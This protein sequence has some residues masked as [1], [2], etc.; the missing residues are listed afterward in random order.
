MNALFAFL[1]ILIVWPGLLL[2]WRRWVA[3]Q[4]AKTLPAG[5]HLLVHS[6]PEKIAAWIFLS[7]VV[8]LGPW[9]TYVA[10]KASGTIG[11]LYL[12]SLSGLLGWLSALYFRSVYN[13]VE[14]TARGIRQRRFSIDTLIPWPDV[15]RITE[16]PFPTALL[17]H[18]CDG[19]KVRLDKLMV[20]VLIVFVY[21]REH[22]S[23]A[24]NYS[25]INYLR[26]ETA[27]RMRVAAGRQNTVSSDG[28][29]DV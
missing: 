28:T 17:I 3:R 15:T 4:P 19:T 23:A 18:G 16:A 8:S 13:R 2:A 11:A 20:G 22:L 14:L 5:G 9:G 25:A 29:E 21:F 27:L 26:P 12:I 1:A 24:L 7:A 6:L 10:W